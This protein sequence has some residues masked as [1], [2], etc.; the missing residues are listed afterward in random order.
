MSSLA[1]VMNNNAIFS[2]SIPNNKLN[3]NLSKEAQK[4]IN[5]Y[6]WLN[7]TIRNT[8]LIGDFKDQKIKKLPLKIVEVETISKINGL[9]KDLKWFIALGAAMRG[10]IPRKD[11]QIISLMNIG[12][13]KAY[14]QEKINS[15][16]NFLISLNAALAIFFFA[17]FMATWSLISIIQNNYIKQ[18]SSFY[19]L[20]SS[21]NSMILNE[22]VADFNSL[23]DQMSVIVQKEPL[24]SKVIEETK[25]KVVVG[26]S[27]NNIALS[28]IDGLLSITGI[29]I[30][31]EAI[32]ALKQS[33]ESS[34]I[35]G[36]VAIP[37]DNLGKK[38][39]IP[40]SMTFR[41]KSPELI[42]NK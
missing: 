36:E 20:P 4:I 42:Y 2:Q 7:I 24:W 17:A 26:I 21:E 37:L 38:V 31:R 33:F 34:E 3:D 10:L 25:N 29:A 22:K 12:T 15:T 27:I 13:E 40:F 5:Y 32:N 18:I 6:D 19:I 11:D 30:N 9:E 41:I 1:V 39:D 23:I 16:T 35:F 14:K 28:S 8:I